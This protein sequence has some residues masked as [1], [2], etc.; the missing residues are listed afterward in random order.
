MD[1]KNSQSASY[2]AAGVDIPQNIYT[3][4]DAEAAL[5]SLLGGVSFFEHDSY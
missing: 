5:T 4:D 2:A 1:H 3:V